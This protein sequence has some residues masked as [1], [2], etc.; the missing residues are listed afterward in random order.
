MRGYRLLDRPIIAA[1]PH[2]ALRGQDPEPPMIRVPEWICRLGQAIFI[3]PTA[4]A[5][6]SALPA[7]IIGQDR[8]WSIRQA[9]S[10]LLTR[11]R[12]TW[13]KQVARFEARP[14]ER[15]TPISHEPW[16][17]IASS[18]VDVGAAGRRCGPA[19]SSYTSTGSKP[20]GT[21]VIRV[22]I[23]HNGID[24]ETCPADFEEDRRTYVRYAVAITDIWPS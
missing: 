15:G 11:P 22:A 18:N 7:P 23:S 10:H 21:Q 24:F 8:G 6:T 9:Q 19:A 14:A 1:D 12:S 2:P 17:N 20:P 5:A 4:D 13:P 16:Q 3:S